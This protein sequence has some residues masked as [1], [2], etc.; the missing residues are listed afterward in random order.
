MSHFFNV[1]NL[2]SQCARVCMSNL[3]MDYAYI[4]IYIH[5]DKLLD[6]VSRV[7]SKNQESLSEKCTQFLDTFK[8]VSHPHFPMTDVP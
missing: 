6:R 7:L 4:H 8:L 2:V 1:T 3:Q 5:K